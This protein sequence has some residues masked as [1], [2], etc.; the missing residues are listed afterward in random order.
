V[1][2]EELQG[3]LSKTY[4]KMDTERC[5]V[6]KNG[7]SQIALNIGES[8]MAPPTPFPESTKRYI[9]LGLPKKYK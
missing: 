6:I 3:E 2:R 7:F 9:I 4:K 8:I 1:K 5:D